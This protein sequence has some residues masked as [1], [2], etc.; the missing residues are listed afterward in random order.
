[1]EI[2]ILLL[3][4]L[5]NTMISPTV[6]F[7]RSSVPRLLAAGINLVNLNL[8]MTYS[9]HLKKIMFRKLQVVYFLAETDEWVNA[10]QFNLLFGKIF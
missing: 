4:N 5:L 1:M 9:Y 8:S 10:V 6:F 2:T 7:T 3:S